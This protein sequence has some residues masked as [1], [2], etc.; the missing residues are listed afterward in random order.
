M[1]SG[2]AKKVQHFPPESGSKGDKSQKALKYC[3]WKVGC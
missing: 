1:F 2:D 3:I